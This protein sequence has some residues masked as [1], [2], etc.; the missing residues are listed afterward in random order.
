MKLAVLDLTPELFVEFCKSSVKGE[1]RRFT[2]KD[3]ALPD[4]VEIVRIRLADDAVWPQTLQLVLRSASF[5]EVAAGAK[6]PMLPP[7]VF[8]TIFDA[9][10]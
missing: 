5:S 4:D 8:E 6:P 10:S 2:V 1:P 7:V 9:R 3:N